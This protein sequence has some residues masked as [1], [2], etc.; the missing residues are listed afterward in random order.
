MPVM[1][2]V[3]RKTDQPDKQG[4]VH[5][6]F[7]HFNDKHNLHQGSKTLDGNIG[8]SRTINSHPGDEDQVEGKI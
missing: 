8:N 1:I 4:I 7:E 3:T 2:K 5:L 6:E